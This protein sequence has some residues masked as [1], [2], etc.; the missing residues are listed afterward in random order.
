[1]GEHKQEP[2]TKRFPI[3]AVATLVTGLTILAIYFAL[4][5]WVFRPIRFS[6]ATPV[7]L[8]SL[9]THYVEYC[10]ERNGEWPSDF[11]A[12]KEYCEKRAPPEDKEAARTYEPTLAVLQADGKSMEADI[13]SRR[14]PAVSVRI[15]L[16][17][18]ELRV[19]P[20]AKDKLR[21]LDR[22]AMIKPRL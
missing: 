4:V 13:G 1:M 22:G 14:Y 6:L 5:I 9:T 3:W 8:T 7:A 18:D 21:R 16:S 20:E 2:G 11:G 15:R 19:S 12:L 17:L 10:V